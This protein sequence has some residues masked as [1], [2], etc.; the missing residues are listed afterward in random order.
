MLL[1]VR[2]AVTMTGDCNLPACRPDLDGGNR[3]VS[4]SRQ[5]P[6]ENANRGLELLDVEKQRLAQNSIEDRRFWANRHFICIAFLLM[7]E[8]ATKT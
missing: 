4:E 5:T 6:R 2:T 1:N 8:T 7:A 3:P